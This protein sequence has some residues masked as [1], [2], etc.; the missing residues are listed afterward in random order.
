MNRGERGRVGAG[1]SLLQ[2]HFVMLRLRDRLKCSP[3]S[4]RVLIVGVLA[5]L[6]GGTVWGYRRIEAQRHWRFAREALTA[7][8]VERARPHLAACV[9]YW[10]NDA[11]VRFW[12]ARAARQAGDYEEAEEHLTACEQLR[13]SSPSSDVDAD[14]ERLMLRAELGDTKGLARVAGDL[15]QSRPAWFLLALEATARGHFATMHYAEAARLADVL[16]Q[17]S[18]AHV[19]GL[20][21]RAAL[22][23]ED[24]QEEKAIECC[25]MALVKVPNAIE[26]RLRM[27]KSL[28]ALGRQQETIQLYETLRSKHPEHPEVLYRLAQ[29]RLDARQTDEAERLLDRLMTERPRHAGALVERGRL[30]LRQGRAEEAE[31]YLRCAL[32]AAPTH[33]EAWDALVMCL[34][35]RGERA[36]AEKCR[37]QRE[38]WEAEYGRVARRKLRAEQNPGDTE[39]LQTVA[40]ELMRLGRGEEALAWYFAVLQLQ[41]R[42]AAVHRALAEYFAHSGQPHRAA[43][44]RRQAETADEASRVASAPRFSSPGASE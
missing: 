21:L 38:Q 27:G 43:H 14:L 7:Q 1:P 41:P 15:E 42:Q 25:R 11:E 8:D 4:R 37:S 9:R 39:M 32:D 10:P 24:Y 23:H 19:Q 5:L 12:S 26:P 22:F 18:P 30:A 44:H 17:R 31:V 2:G 20:L 40:D 16:L 3:P 33:A 13:P 34:E 29:C 28:M 35:A 36:E 6:A